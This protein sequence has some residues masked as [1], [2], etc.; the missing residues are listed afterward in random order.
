MKPGKP[1]KTCGTCGAR[2]PHT[3]PPVLTESQVSKAPG[4]RKRMA[5]FFNCP[6]CFRPV[7]SMNTPNHLGIITDTCDTCLKVF[8]VRLKEYETPRPRPRD[9]DIDNHEHRTARPTR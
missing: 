9:T 8:R 6:K 3:C 4:S 2:K 5:L 7:C 1:I